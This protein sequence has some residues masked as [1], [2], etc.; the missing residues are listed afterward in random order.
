MARGPVIVTRPAQA[1]ASLV[2][3]LRAAGWDALHWPAFELLPPRE[4]E[5]ARARLAQVTPGELL[6]FVS[7]T[8]VRACADVLPQW[9]PGAR[10]ASV[11]AGTARALHAAYGAAVDCLEPESAPGEGGS[12]ALFARLAGMPW[13]SRVLILRAEQGREWLAEQ[14]Q[15]AGV[16]VEALSVYRRE[17]LRLDPAARSELA[18][19]MG[20]GRPPVLLVSS[21]EAVEAL[22]KAVAAIPSAWDWLRGG[23]ARA[24]HA[25]IATALRQAG[26]AIV[27]LVQA[28]EEAVLAKLESDA[29][30]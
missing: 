9:P 4:P 30:D 15:A 24:I 14:L 19:V 10:A 3:R 20:S 29:P 16:A 6:V 28:D 23:T 13:P 17:P 25:R 18:R 12:E 26:F 22:H 2:Q 1:G 27:S 21:T 11:G 7:P 5:R 8:A